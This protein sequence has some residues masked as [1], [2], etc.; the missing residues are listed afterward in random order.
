[1]AMIWILLAVLLLGLAAVIFFMVSQDAN[2]PDTARRFHEVLETPHDEAWLNQRKWRQA[3]RLSYRFRRIL[4]RLPGSDMQEI[5]PLLRQAALNEERSRAIFYLSLWVAP[6]C[7]AVLGLIFSSTGKV[8]PEIGTVFGLG[9]GYIIPR[10]L[11]RWLAQRRQAVIREE[12]PIVLNLMRLL[13]D[14]GLSIEHTLKAISEQARS[15]TPE[16]STEMAWVLS[17]I[18]H[19]QD[20]GEALE[21]MAKRIDVSELTETIAILKQSAKYGGSVRDSLMRYLKLL[22]DRRLTD[23]RDKVGKLSAQMTIVMMLCL[24]PGLLV[25]LA[26]PAV[27]SIIKALG[28]MQ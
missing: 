24:F 12:L 10:R 23:L 27:I 25:F 5:E 21:E 9:L 18:Q 26:G 17:R 16:L 6:L 13:F 2:Q 14:A 22:E 4:E 1:M 15:I 28:S 7:C 20:R 19:G 8:T 3:Q 11:L